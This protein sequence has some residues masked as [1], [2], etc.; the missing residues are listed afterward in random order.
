LV[1]KIHQ[2]IVKLLVFLPVLFNLSG[3]VYLVVGGI[4]ALGGYIVSPDTVEGITENDAMSVWDGAVEVISIM[5]LIQ[6]QQEEAGIIEAKI[7]KASV[8]VTI[9]SI[10]ETTT[11]VSVKARRA[12]MPRISTAQDVYVKVMSF[13]NE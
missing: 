3:C 11:K 8:T 1:R 5:G 13:V 12:Y 7:N 6:Q 9:S 4:G 10:N 2:R